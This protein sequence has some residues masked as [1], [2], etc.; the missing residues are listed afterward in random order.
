MVVIED[1]VVAARYVPRDCRK[2]GLEGAQKHQN[3]RYALCV[4]ANRCWRHL[5][6]ADYGIG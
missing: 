5:S 3:S 6:H 1:D 2:S 4:P